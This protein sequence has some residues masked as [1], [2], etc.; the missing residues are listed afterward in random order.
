MTW[1]ELKGSFIMEPIRP[2][3]TTAVATHIRETKHTQTLSFSSIMP[4]QTALY[5]RITLAHNCPE[6]F[7]IIQDGSGVGQLAVLSR[8]GQTSLYSR[9]T[10]GVWNAINE[11]IKTNEHQPSAEKA[12]KKANIQIQDNTCACSKLKWKQTAVS[13]KLFTAGGAYGKQTR[14]VCEGVLLKNWKKR[15][16]WSAVEA[17]CVC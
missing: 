15:K 14:T 7:C 12:N 11:V 3:S 4:P 10:A 13:A 6:R 8:D 2:H 1:T 16:H 17:L 5:R 9:D